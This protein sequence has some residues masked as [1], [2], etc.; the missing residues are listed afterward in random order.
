MFAKLLK[1]SETKCRVV[2]M[3]SKASH[4]DLFPFSYVYKVLS[5][6]TPPSHYPVAILVPSPLSPSPSDGPGADCRPASVCLHRGRTAVVAA[7]LHEMPSRAL[8]PVY[9]RN[10]I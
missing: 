8:R 7:V 3:T 4:S 5:S 10:T 1:A 2:Q 9:R 6:Q